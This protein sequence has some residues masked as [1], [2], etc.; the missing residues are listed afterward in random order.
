MHTTQVSSLRYFN[1]AGADGSG[2]IGEMHDPETH[3][4]PIVL[5]ATSGQRNR[6]QIFGTDYPTKDGTCIRDYVHVNDLAQAH[7]LA[8]D[9]HPDG[10]PAGKTIESNATVLAELARRAGAEVEVEPIIPDDAETIA[11]HVRD[12][13][14]ALEPDVYGGG[15]WVGDAV[16]VVHH[17]HAQY[18][19]PPNGTCL[20]GPIRTTFP[21]SSGTPSVNTSDRCLPI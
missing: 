18:N 6:I 10:A 17:H 21:S 20:S 14:V 13:G 19:L 11:R 2:E 15:R 1:A 3:L 7:L 5:Q 9:A 4:I 8:L 12:E 16:A